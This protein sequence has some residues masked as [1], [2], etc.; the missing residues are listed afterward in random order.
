MYKYN[1]IYRAYGKLGFP[2]ASRT[3]FDSYCHE[4]MYST[5]KQKLKLNYATHGNKW[6]NGTK[7]ARFSCL[8][9]TTSY[10]MLTSRCWKSSIVQ[11]KK[12]TSIS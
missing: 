11:Q 2:R 5:I 3:Y 10:A 6:Q 7:D 8:T 9:V 4:F 1:R 12:I